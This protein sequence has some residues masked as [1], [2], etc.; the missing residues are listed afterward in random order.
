MPDK[1]CVPE[2]GQCRSCALAAQKGPVNGPLPTS[3]TEV[4]CLYKFQRE[5]KPPLCPKEKLSDGLCLNC[6]SR[7]KFRQQL[8]D[9]ASPLPELPSQSSSDAEEV[10]TGKKGGLKIVPRRRPGFKKLTIEIRPPKFKKKLWFGTYELEDV[11]RAKDAINFYM[12]SNL[13]YYLQDSPA[14]FAQHRLRIDYR[15]LLPS[16]EQFLQVEQKQMRATAFFA[17]EV[18]RVIQTVTGKKRG[19]QRR[20]RST[21]KN[22]VIKK[23]PTPEPVV[24]CA[25][26]VTSLPCTSDCAS[27][28]AWEETSNVAVAA[29]ATTTYGASSSEANSELAITGNPP[30]CEVFTSPFEF[31]EDES[32]NLD[33]ETYLPDCNW[34]NLLDG[35]S[36]DVEGEP[37]MMEDNGSFPCYFR[38]P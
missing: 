37:G 12:R 28:T 35:S 21:G 9:Q 31:Q 13:P 27:A 29:A 17:R 3:H 33:M 2:F 4:C 18:K 16:C 23:E 32:F 25:S 7:L 34:W 1:P 11:D 26:G 5:G 6:P 10:N 24:S 38:W 20:P 15:E 14:I 19:Q 8:Q 36:L 22:I 30:C